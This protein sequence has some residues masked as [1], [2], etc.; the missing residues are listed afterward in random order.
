ML[1]K[2]RDIMKNTKRNFIVAAIS[3]FLIAAIIFASSPE[4]SFYIK[5]AISQSFS[6]IQFR[7]INKSE[8][9]LTEKNLKL[10]SNSSDCKFN[11]S[12]LLVN[13]VNLLSEDFEAELTQY[14]NTTA[15]IN[16]CACDDFIKMRNELQKEFGERLL[17]MSSYR[18]RKEQERLLAEE[19]GK[20]AAKPGE[21]EHETGLALDVYVK[22]F[23]GKGFIKTEI[24]KYVNKNCGNYGF[25]IRYPL[26]KK[27]ITGFDYEPWHL[28][29]VGF[30]HSKIISDSG[31]TLEEYIKEIKID[32]FYR[33]EN[34]IISKQDGESLLIP[35]NS[36]N[37]IISPDNCGNYIITCE[38]SN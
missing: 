38:I 4:I 32:C 28:R 9:N 1:P 2:G 29:Y 13:S 27:D 12:L 20:T 22:Y 11:Q 35:E 21:S 6:K 33:Y 18:S 17:I 19:G 5:T 8:L 23:A 16:S 26:G 24:G 15:L 14:E 36:K 25:I 10:L 37:T 31:M 30:P 34:Y 3:L 7:E